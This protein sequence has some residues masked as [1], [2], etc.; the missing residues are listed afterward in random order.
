MNILKRWVEMYFQMCFEEVK[1]RS[2][3]LRNAR[4]YIPGNVQYDRLL[5]L[6]SFGGR[7]TGTMMMRVVGWNL[8][9]EMGDSWGSCPPAKS[10]SVGH[11]SCRTPCTKRERN[12]RHDL[13]SGSRP[14][15][16]FS[17]KLCLIM[18]KFKH[19]NTEFITRRLG[20]VIFKM[21]T[22]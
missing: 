4:K 8:D 16:N 10:A 6:A 11:V 1:W 15:S 3:F 18:Q 19:M 5:W 17:P 9:S 2:L 21:C 12:K 13:T 22:N 7:T 20:D 14:G